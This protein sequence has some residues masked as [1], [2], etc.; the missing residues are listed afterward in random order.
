VPLVDTNNLLS[1]AEVAR[2]TGESRATVMNRIKAGELKATRI[3]NYFV[4]SRQDLD[5]MQKLRAKAADSKA[6]PP[7]KAVSAP[8]TEEAPAK[9]GRGRPRKSEE[10]PAKATMAPKEVTPIPKI[11][12]KVETPEAPKRRG[13]PPK[14]RVEEEAQLELAEAPVVKRPR[15]RPRKDGSPPQ[16]KVAATP[17]VR[18][19]GRLAPETPPVVKR[20]RGRPRKI[21]A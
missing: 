16:P 13:R 18:T 19:K 14:I 9:R 17:V 15:G 6:A 5:R 2:D 12:A 4:I 7:V 10:A 8:A 20:G 1:V 21:L 11:K 3:G